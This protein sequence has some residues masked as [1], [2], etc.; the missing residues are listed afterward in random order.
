MRDKTIKWAF[1]GVIVT[2]LA[3]S[4]AGCASSAR[5]SD[6]Q[7]KQYNPNYRP[8]PGEVY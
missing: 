3:L 4:L 7:W 6:W 5:Y 2:A 8:L 1:I